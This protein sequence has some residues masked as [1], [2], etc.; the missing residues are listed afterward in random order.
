MNILIAD[1]HP[2]LRAG[3]VKIIAAEPDFQIVAEAGDGEEALALIK[4]HGPDLAVLDISMPGKSGLEI[5]KECRKEKMP[6]EFIILTMYKE[7]EYFNEALDLGVKGYILKEN[8]SS[9]LINCM[10]SVSNGKYYVSPIISDYLV[11]R[12]ARQRDLYNET[13]TLRDLTPMERTVLKLIA[14]NKTS[15][16]IASELYISFR[17]VQNHRTNICGKLDLKGY[18]KL[19]QFAIEHKSVL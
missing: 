1:D 9:D 15:K 11:N 2:I 3:L 13:P 19:L 17:T 8:A 16:E 18:N 6:I 5:V 10:K 14:E 12:N 7:E 4:E